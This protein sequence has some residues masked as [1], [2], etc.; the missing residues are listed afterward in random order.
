MA[1]LAVHI[2][3][4]PVGKPL[5]YIGGGF[6]GHHAAKKAEQCQRQ[7]AQ[8]AEDHRS[9]HALRR[10][11]GVHLLINAVGKGRQCQLADGLYDHTGGADGCQSP[12]PFHIF[13]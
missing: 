8:A 5:A 9:T 3:S 1:D 12:Q 10:G 13:G 6:H 11:G 2:P 4:Q 7:H